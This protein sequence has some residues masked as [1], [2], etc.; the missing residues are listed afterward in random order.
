VAAVDAM[1]AEVRLIDHLFHNPSPD[2]STF[3]EALNPDSLA[4]VQDALLE[5]AAAASVD[6]EVLQFERLGYF[7]RDRDSTPAKP[8]FVRTVGLRDTFAKSLRQT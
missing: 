2:L 4:I 5:P 8:V 3:E 6:G 1:P 7:C